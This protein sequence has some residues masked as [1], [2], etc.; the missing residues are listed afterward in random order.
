M[1][2]KQV[3]S[4]TVCVFAMKTLILIIMALQNLI[5]VTFWVKNEGFF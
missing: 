4:V 5:P 3:S 2:E 1:A